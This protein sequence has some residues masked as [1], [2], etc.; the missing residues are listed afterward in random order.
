M[1]EFIK[2]FLPESVIKYRQYWLKNKEYINWVK[3]GRPL[4]PHA[5]AKQKVL[6]EYKNKYN[7]HV[8]VE[9]G[10]CY[11]GTIDAL[12][13]YFKQLISIEVSTQL[14]I[15]AKQKFAKYSHIKL[16]EGDSGLLLPEIIKGINE[17]CLFWLDGHYSGA[18]TGKG[19]LNTP[20]FKELSAIFSSKFNHV[21]IIDDARLFVG[22]EDY[23]SIEELTDFVKKLKPTANLS[24]ELDMIRIVNT[25]LV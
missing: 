2:N 14:Y 9:T 18:D 20:I 7:L 22:K 17:P 23:P 25:Q 10:T 13:K 6:L 1:K 12:K 21:I 5:I 15:L 16:Y 19:E 3:A 24:V 8:L 4:P 11:G